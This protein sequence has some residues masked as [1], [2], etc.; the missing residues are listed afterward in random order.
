[1]SWKFKL[2]YGPNGRA[3]GGLAWDGKS[4]LVSDAMDLKILSFAAGAKEPTVFRKWTNRV[5]GIAFGPGG[6]LYGCQEGS[7]RVIEMKPDGSSVVTT[8]VIDGAQ[9]N[10]PYNAS[11]DKKGRVWF[12]DRLHAVLASGPQVFPYLPHQSVLRMTLMGRPHTEWH[13]ERMTYDTKS[14]RGVAVSPDEKT[15][16]VAETQT[17][18]G[19]VRELRAYPILADGT[20]GPCSV[21]HS[22]GADHRGVHRGI[23]GICV[24]RDGNIFACAGWS[25]S[26]PG[27][28]VYVFDPSGRVVESH[29][30]PEGTPLNCAFGGADLSTLYVTTT[31][32]HLYRAQT[33]YAGYLLYKAA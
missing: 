27:P 22:F 29:A 19:G 6:I 33:G 21:L 17:V 30:L 32:G 16:Y 12:S 3:L 1:M 4:M 25:R 8:T 9:Y 10:H 7:R 2:V 28:T 31:E 23:D 13:V 5:N 15:L 14:P 18:P 24:G 20:L 11:I 26:G